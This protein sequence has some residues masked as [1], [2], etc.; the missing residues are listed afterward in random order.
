MNLR[1]SQVKDSSFRHFIE[2]HRKTLYLYA[3]NKPKNEKNLQML[4]KLSTTTNEPVALINAQ[5]R[6]ISDSDKPVLGH[7]DLK[8]ITLSSPLC[9]GCKVAIDTINI[10]P[11]WGLYNGCLGTVVDIVYDHPQGPNNYTTNIPKYVIVDV[12]EF[13]PPP[14]VKVWDSL[15]PTVSNSF[16]YGA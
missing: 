1:L 12:P 5:F 11:T 16:I 3:T 2:N 15:H 13:Q 14:N 8:S 6:H 7:F 9:I 4:H 10:C